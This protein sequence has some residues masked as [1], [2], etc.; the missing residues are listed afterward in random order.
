MRLRPRPWKE[1]SLKTDA[2]P[3]PK[4]GFS[5]LIQNWKSDMISG[6]LVFLI[7]LPLCLGI[8]LASGY[9]AIA[10]IFTAIIGGLLCPLQSDSELTIKGPAAG[11]IVIALG[12]VQ[13][14]GG[15]D[16]MLGYKLALG[17]GVAAG[18]IQVL[19]GLLRTGILGEFFPI[20][21]VHGMLAAIGIIIASKQFHVLLGV[22]PEGKEPL[23][24]L[25]EI[26]QSLAH[27]NP[28]VAIIGLVSLLILF[29]LPLVRSRYL[30]M[31]PAPMVVLLVAVPIGLL[32]NLMNEHTYSFG[33][34]TF[35]LG[36]QYLVDLPSNL[37]RAVQTP[38]FHGLT[39]WVG[40]K[41]VAMFALVGILES[42]LSAKAIDLLDPYKRKTNLNRDLVAVGIANT[43][44]S[45]IGGLPMI[46]EIVRSS[47]NINNGAKTRW[48]NAF[49]GLFLLIFA[50]AIP[51]L[52]HRIPLAALAAM[53]IYTGYRLASPKEFVKTF[54]VGSEQLVIFLTTIVVTLATD[55]LLGIAVGIGVKFLIH[56]INGVPLRSLFKPYIDVT[57][58]PDG[59]IQISARHSAVFSNWIPFRRQIEQLGLVQ[60][61]NVVL[62]LSQT[63]IVDHSVMERLHEMELQFQ[64]AGLELV[65]VGLEGHRSF[66]RHPFSARKQG[67]VSIRRITVIAP[68]ELE[69]P[70]VFE[71]ARRGATGFTAIDCGG[72]GRHQLIGGRV[73]REPRVRL[74]VLVPSEAANLILD[75]IRREVMPQHPATACVETVQVVRF[76]QFV[77]PVET[78]E[79]GRSSRVD[80]PP[81]AVRGSP[82][83][84]VA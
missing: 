76:D 77:G 62:D 21:A 58:H 11:L 81:G 33:G 34:A 5:G 60:H 55:L 50:A 73:D 82:T 28:A 43:L 12:A 51:G 29:G 79:N 35:S 69:Q 19:F 70:L 68:K 10:G 83:T 72:A 14:L 46:S 40:I 84:S 24:L 23:E 22:K 38:D 27:C 71:F 4:A 6:F 56:L 2:P 9:P 48:A 8:S 63:R 7:A 61:K 54:Q 52:L 66:S 80:R 37:F 47:A 30:K 41:Y 57:D 67:L 53:L 20:S 36:P 49:H 75:H 45:L 78:V 16:P 25:A 18:V 32:F 44:S 13:E 31:V 26:P 3:V 42:L 1:S 74:E 39:T 15:N 59:A 64:E 65:V 17:I